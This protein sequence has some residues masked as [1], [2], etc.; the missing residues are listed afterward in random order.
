MTLID[1]FFGC[2]HSNVS[3]PQKRDGETIQVC[4]GCG[5]EFEYDWEQMRRGNRRSI[6]RA[7]DAGRVEEPVHPRSFVERVLRKSVHV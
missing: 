2:K 3:F 6:T 7:V 5:A 1:L 4:L